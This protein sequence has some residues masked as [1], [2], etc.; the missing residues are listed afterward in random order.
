MLMD[1]R[2]PAPGGKLFGEMVRAAIAFHLTG[3]RFH[4]L[5]RPESDWD[6]FVQ[7]APGVGATLLAMGFT[8]L[9]PESSYEAVED[10][11]SDTVDVLAVLDSEADTMVQV[12]L[13][14]SV[15][16]A[17]AVRDVIRAH[18]H[19]RDEILR[20]LGDKTERRALWRACAAF[21]RVAMPEETAPLPAMAAAVGAAD[22]DDSLPF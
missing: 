21:V 7:D 18:F 10:D 17:Q 19:G 1:M 3:S 16:R 12:Q 6:F 20:A 13:V 15:A 22:D 2:G 4:G 11:A 9:G 14:V 5:E 8:P